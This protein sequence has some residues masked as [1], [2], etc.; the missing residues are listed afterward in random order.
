MFW[1]SL[2]F[3][4]GQAVLVVLWVDVPNL[5]EAGSRGGPTAGHVSAADQPEGRTLGPLVLRFLLLIWPVF[6]IESAFHWLTRPWNRRTRSD[7]LFSLLFCLCPS[8]RMCARSP[9]MDHRLWLPGLGWRKADR[10]LRRHLERRFSVPMILIALLIMPVLIVEFFLKQQVA[11]NAWL[12]AALHISTGVIWF[13]FAA[14]FILMVSAAEKKLIYV[15]NHWVDLA[16]ILLPLLSFLRSLQV[17]RASRAF[18]I[19]R[20]P[21]LG[22]LVRVYR[23]R[24]TALKA[25]RALL[26]LDVLHRLITPD[27]EK[28]IARLRRQVKELERESRLLR[29]KI[30]RLREE[31]DVADDPEQA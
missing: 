18:K 11:E 6:L 13:A 27:P 17:L 28:R 29:Q 21:Q 10:R 24:G 23:L 20:L 3:L 9:E 4:V 19:A 26:V 31:K 8:L 1:L 30:A 22:R 7:H 25:F 16:I 5:H 2:A 15:K 14:E 12:R